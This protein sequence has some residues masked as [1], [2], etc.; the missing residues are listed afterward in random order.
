ML[1]HLSGSTTASA[2]APLVR[3]GHALFG[4]KIYSQWS[5]DTLN[6]Q[7][8]P[9]A[10]SGHHIRFF[11]VRD[12]R[13]DIV[14]DAWLMVMDYYA[15][16]PVTGIINSNYDYQDNIYLITNMRPGVAP[17][18][19]PL[20]ASN[21]MGIA[22]DWDDNHESTLLGYN[23]YRSTSATGSF[24]KVNT[25]PVIGSKY[26]DASAVVG[27]TY[28]YRVTALSSYGRSPATRQWPARCGRRTPC[29]RACRSGWARPGRAA[30]SVWVGLRP[31]TRTPPGIASTAPR[32]PTAPGRC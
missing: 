9:D 30:A 17:P 26:T 28:Y 10:N 21:S 24:V 1:P 6:I 16:D 3:H 7:E 14:P 20:A 12:D 5:D 32:P 23:V 13:G 4:F 22:L 27:T 18:T 19:N 11:P 31:V 2:R 29:R 8:Q 15:V 25:Q